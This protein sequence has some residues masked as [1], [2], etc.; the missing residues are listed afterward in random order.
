M[1]CESVTI[2]TIYKDNAMK[3]P[4][5]A[6]SLAELILV[7]MFIGIL[8]AIAVPRINF[9]VI[10]KQKVDTVTK[11]MVTDLR[12]TRS[13]A[14]TYAATNSTGY[15]IK[16]TGFPPY[17]GYEIWDR[18]NWKMIDSHTFD[19]DIVCTGNQFFRFGTMGNL[20]DVSGTLKLSSQGR[21]FTISVVPATG[22]I[23]CVEN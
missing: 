3:K 5:K 1:Q 6:Y 8:A 11:K 19:S 16:M 7:V 13:M 20:L 18:T 12:R 17:K 15:G 9:G 10:S 22:M 14:I 21:S 2:L 4:Q 23:K